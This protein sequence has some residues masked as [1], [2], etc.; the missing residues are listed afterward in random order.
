MEAKF[1]FEE[2]GTSYSV[3]IN[4]LLDTVR[5]ICD[6]EDEEESLRDICF[7]L[8]SLS[9]KMEVQ[10]ENLRCFIPD[11]CH[12]PEFLKLKLN[13]F[14]R[15]VNKIE[16]Y[17]LHRKKSC[18]SYEAEVLAFITEEIFLLLEKLKDKSAEKKTFSLFPLLDEVILCA[19][20]IEKGFF[21]DE[22]LLEKLDF[23]EDFVTVTKEQILSLT[24]EPDSVTFME[25]I[26]LV[27]DTLERL[28]YGLREFRKYLNCRDRKFIKSGTDITIKATT[29]L[30]SSLDLLY[31]ASGIISKI[32]CLHCGGKNSLFFDRCFFC[33]SVLPK[34]FQ[35]SSEIKNEEYIVD[36]RYL[37]T[38]NLNYL[39]ES[40]NDIERG[41]IS[42]KDFLEKLAFVRN[43]IDHI[44]K[45]LIINFTDEKGKFSSAVYIFE[46]IIDEIAGGIDLISRYPEERNSSYLDEGLTVIFESSKFFSYFQSL[47]IEAEKELLRRY[48]DKADR[49]PVDS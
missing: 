47:G 24:G 8:K 46:S 11:D 14:F 28:L 18:L 42:G 17:F 20:D 40:V 10:L 19:G 39:L 30:I 25:E 36:F 21:P 31:E 7:I 22:A 41:E 33:S 49:F 13:D 12:S 1:P 48:S 37:L 16:E 44:K 2:D 43:K 32:I 23:L 34:I 5:A 35:D 29:S 26:P 9:E 27:L 6:G 4:I 45:N 3:Y 15:Q 38:S